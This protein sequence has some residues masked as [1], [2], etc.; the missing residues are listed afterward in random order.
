MNITPR[1]ETYI[2]FIGDILMLVL[3]LWLVLFTRYAVIPDISLYLGH[4]L[5]FSILFALWFFVFFISGLYEK[6]TLFLKS[7][8]PSL[9]F[10]A[11]I[12]NSIFAV[13]FFYFIPYFSITPKTNL[14]LMLLYSFVLLAV[15][16]L[17]GISLLS[18]SKKGHVLIV[19]SG[20]EINELKEEVGNN[21][22]YN[23]KSVTF[24]DTDKI[25]DANFQNEV[26]SRIHNNKD[27]SV[28]MV[29][30][31][32]TKIQPLLPHFYKLLFSQICFVDIYDEYEEIFNRVP[33]SLINYT[34]LLKNISPTSKITYD[35]L[36][37]LMDIF[38]ALCV[39]VLSL[40][41]IFFAILAIKI[42]DRGPIFFLQERI[43]KNN[44]KIE[45]IKFRS[46]AVSKEGVKNRWYC[47]QTLQ[48]TTYIGKILRKI[49]IDELP[50][51]WNV[52]KGDIS[53]IGPR[54]E[55]P[56]LAQAYE[57]AISYYSIRH[58]IKPG[59]SGWAQVNQIIPPK[60]S[61]EYDKTKTK[62]SYDLYYVKNRSVLLDI[63]IGLQTIKT[64]FSRSGV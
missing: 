23:L 16:R 63:K 61:V 12:L 8:I 5:P 35:I 45:I 38:I 56:K 24:L 11:Q 34:W 9:I 33:S 6:H 27:L 58:I 19:G 1:K 43:G 21:P 7:Q 44:K 59:L 64:L 13:C 60:F 26:F 37:R 28:I 31:Q 3:A 29:D 40:V 20:E 42:S 55:T 39:G 52:L 46:M 4:F 10:Y 36:K 54:P 47:R 2:L 25:S 15:W 48:I 57:Q 41:I 49:H 62:L 53:L 30:L 32:N 51:L 14:F 50:Q 17:Y 18:F 22:R